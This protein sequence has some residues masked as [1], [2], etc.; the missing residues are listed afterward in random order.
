MDW[1]MDT[2]SASGRVM[3]SWMRQATEPPTSSAASDSPMIS[4]TETR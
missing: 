1:A 2:A 4:H 3:L